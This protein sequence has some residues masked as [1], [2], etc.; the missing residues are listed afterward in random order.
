MACSVP[1]VVCSRPVR[2]L[3]YNADL[4]FGSRKAGVFP[5][6]PESSGLFELTLFNN[7]FQ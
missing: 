1:R 2:E 7:I 3:G 5:E 4:A 6:G